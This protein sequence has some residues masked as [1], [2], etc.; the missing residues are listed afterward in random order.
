MTECSNCGREVPPAH[1]CVACGEPLEE[2]SRGFAAN[3]HERW[4]HPRVV[5]SIFPHLPR[6]DM[7]P[8]RIALLAATA[9]VIVLCLLRLYPL[10]LVAAA[11]SVPLL[12]IVYLLDVDVYEDEPFKVVGF[13]VGWGAIAGAGLGIA[14]R[15]V[16][17][18]VSLLQGSPDTHDLVW[19]GIVLPLAAVA[20]MLAGPLLL[21]P[22]KKFDDCLDGVVFGATCASTLLAAEAIANSSSLLHLGFRAAGDQSLWI[23]RLLTLGV[24]LP[25]LAAGVAGATCGA[26]WLRYRGPAADRGALGIL[27]S[28][29]VGVLISAAALVG[30]SVAQLYLG[31]WTVLGLTAA[32]AGLA[33]VWLRMTL[34]LGLREESEEKPIGQPVKCPSCKHETPHHTFCGNCGVN[35]RALPKKG[36]TR[37]SAG[38]KLAVFGALAAAAVGI[39]A[40]V[41]ALTRPS[42][43]APPCQPG[44][45]CASP[46]SSPISLPRVAAVSPFQSGVKWTSDLGPV[47][48]Y[49]KHFDVVSKGKRELVVKGQA[50]SGLFIVVAVFVLPSSQTPASGIASAL[51]N[52]RDGSFLGVDSDNSKKVVILSPEIGYV[53]GV[54]GMYH[55]T[56]DQSPSPSQQ[57]EIAFMAARHGAATVVV[58]GITNEDE[59]GGHADSPFPAFEVVDEILTS[60]NWGVP[61]T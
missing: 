44:V 50:P 10:A 49:P 11:I 33:L 5:S 7:R 60:F 23:P 58:E 25:V 18:K 43:P 53:H 48:Y 32:L 55:A 45:P 39:A 24:T 28:P 3:P 12:F 13:T 2:G 37:W 51:R 16:A 35:F 30:A 8:F 40:V 1:F 61:P 15:E 20:L 19:L 56:V 59:Q 22:Y 14:A 52:E 36:A 57:V 29:P 6:A 47:L 38:V 21:L 42:P 34:Q 31:H 27:G 9:F 26:F 46:P 54:A 17:S 4:W 41:I